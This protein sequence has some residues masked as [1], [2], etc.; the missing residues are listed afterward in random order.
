MK[1]ILAAGRLLHCSSSTNSPSL[2]GT[3]FHFLNDIIVFPREVNA[4]RAAGHF[5]RLRIPTVQRLRGARLPLNAWANAD[6]ATDR[7]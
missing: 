3:T 6:D 2:G 1:G 4:S 7:G 5:Q